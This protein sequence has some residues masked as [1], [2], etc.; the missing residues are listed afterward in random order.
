MHRLACLRRTAA[1]LS[2]EPDTP[3]NVIFTAISRRE[4]ER[5]RKRER[6]RERE[7]EEE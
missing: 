3:C 7:R 5:V 6:E 2:L 1:R 4:K